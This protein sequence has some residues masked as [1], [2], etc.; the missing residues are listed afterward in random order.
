MA[1]S[2]RL[3]T[4]DGKYYAPE[5]FVKKCVDENTD[6]IS[7]AI[8][9]DVNPKIQELQNNVSEVQGIISSFFTMNTL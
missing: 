2:S 5:D 8:S 7:G 4:V 9:G 1:T 3:K 6:A